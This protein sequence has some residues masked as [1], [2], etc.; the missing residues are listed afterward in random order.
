MGKPRKK[1]RWFLEQ[2]LRFID[3]RLAREG[4]INRSDLVSFFGISVPQASSDLAEYQEMARGNAVY[5]KARKAYVAGEGF[6]PMFLEP[7]GG[8]A[9]MT[10]PDVVDHVL[11]ALAAHDALYVTSLPAG[12]ARGIPP[13]VAFKPMKGTTDGG[14]VETNAVEITYPGGERFVLFVAPLGTPGEAPPP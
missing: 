14:L 3:S 11:K 13:G 2:R 7:T 1:L 4:R 5:D 10:T 9:M 6:E 12:Q 8:P